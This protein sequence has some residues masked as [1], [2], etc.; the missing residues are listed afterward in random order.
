MLPISMTHF[1]SPKQDIMETPKFPLEWLESRMIGLID[2]ILYQE[3]HLEMA[4]K[5]RGYTVYP[6]T[7]CM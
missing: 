7:A 1:F 5:M 4:W 6:F 2:Y 3:R